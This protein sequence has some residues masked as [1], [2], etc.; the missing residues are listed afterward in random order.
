[1]QCIKT[2]D[3]NQQCKRCVKSNSKYCWQHSDDGKLLYFSLL[4]ADLLYLLFFNFNSTELLYTLVTIR[5]ISIFEKIFTSKTF[6]NKI[7]RRDVSSYLPLPEN[8][9][10]TYKNIFDELS[11]IDNDNNKIRYLAMNGYDVLLLPLLEKIPNRYNWAM[12]MAGQGG[13]LPIVRMM[14]R[15]GAIDYDS[16]LLYAAEAGDK[17]IVKLMLNF[18]ADPNIGLAWAKNDEIKDLILSYRMLSK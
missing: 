5:D 18:G 4:P 8:P 11:K 13:Q 16:T 12:T 7:W 2:L 1:M 10:E 17:D 14:L 3:N 9:Y 6:W 15:K